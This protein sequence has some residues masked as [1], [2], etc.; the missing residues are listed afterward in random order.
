MLQAIQRE[1]KEHLANNR[2]DE[3]F[4]SLLSQVLSENC[5]LYN[6]II[7]K[8]AQYNAIRE[9]ERKGIIEDNARDTE[10][11]Q[12]S[13][14]L[15]QYVDLIQP[16]DIRDA[17]R[18]AAQSS[19]SIA[20][21]H[22]YT[23]DRVNQNDEFQLAYYENEGRKVHIFH[24]YGDA[25]QSLYSLCERLGYELGEYLLNWE[26]KDYRPG[27]RIKFE[28]LKPAVHRIPK[29]FSINTMKQLFAKFYPTLSGR[30]PLTGKTINDLLESPGLQDF[31]AE[32]M[33]FVLLTM[34]DY[35]WSREVSPQVIKEFVNSFCNT[36]LPA[37]APRFFFFFGTEYQK[38]NQ[39]VKEE[40]AD[41]LQHTPEFSGQA[42]D[43]I[44]PVAVTDIEEWFS[45]YR[46]FIEKGQDARYMRTQLFPNADTV[47]M[48]DIENVLLKLIETYNKG[49]VIQAKNIK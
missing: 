16:T 19:H 14:A 48:Q 31:T 9:R 32:D 5:K 46:I 7:G 8:Q 49:L 11:N 21:Y 45:R 29:L 39:K 35:N 42:L 4:R 18:N 10:L 47:D 34:D 44:T 25:R 28:T 37:N 22:A 20:P 40:V 17:M 41:V 38:D 2:F 1:L 43:E 27:R 24:L 33:V 12:M 13:D 26:D 6:D 15:L 30:E 23:V 3:V 36:E